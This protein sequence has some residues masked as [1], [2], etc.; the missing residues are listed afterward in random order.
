MEKR[1]WLVTGTMALLLASAA[2]A[3]P[4]RVELDYGTSVK[5]SKFNQTLNPEAAKNLEPVSGFDGGA[6][7]ATLERYQKDFEKPSPPPTYTLSIGSFG[8]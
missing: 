8:K 3:G 6:A 5:L 2:C 4:S 7:K 1:I